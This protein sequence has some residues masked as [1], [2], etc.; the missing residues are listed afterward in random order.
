MKGTN[1]S[2]EPWILNDC[3]PVASIG[4]R[5]IHEGFDFIWLHNQNPFFVHKDKV[6]DLVLEEDIPYIDNRK[7]PRKPSQRERE[8]ILAARNAYRNALPVTPLDGPTSPNYP[9][10]D[11]VWHSTDDQQDAPAN[12]T[13]STDAPYDSNVLATSTRF[14][15]DDATDLFAPLS[16]LHE[17]EIDMDAADDDDVFDNTNGDVREADARSHGSPGPAQQVSA[18]PVGGCLSTPSRALSLFCA[19]AHIKHV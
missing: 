2:A 15:D 12:G 10:I 14:S 6:I 8:V 13:G 7:Q 9:S 5:C 19:A 18:A 4:K 11:N 17:T 1:S 3:P 16:P